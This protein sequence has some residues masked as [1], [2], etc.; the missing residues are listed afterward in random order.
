M[1]AANQ[2]FGTQHMARALGDITNTNTDSGAG[3]AQGGQSGPVAAGWAVKSPYDYRT[4][5]TANGENQQASEQND[6]AI[7]WASNANRYEWDEDFG[8]VGPPNPVLEAQLF[9]GDN[10]SRAGKHVDA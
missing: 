7:G 5:N 9:G 4:Y 3:N 10:V 1:A 8:D 2:S 6:E